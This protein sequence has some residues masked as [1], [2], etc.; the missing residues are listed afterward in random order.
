MNVSVNSTTR[1][2]PPHCYGDPAQWDKNAPECAGG[3][4]ANYQNP[5]TGK[6]VRYPCNF[7]SSCGTR[8]ALAGPRVIPP[9][10][11]VRPPVVTPAPSY[12]PYAAQPPPPQ[13]PPPQPGNLGEY[14]RRVEQERLA[15]LGRQY[16]PPQQY[17]HPGTWSQGYAVPSF[18]SAEEVRH[19]G[20]SWWA[21]FLRMAARGVVKALGMVAAHW[22]DT[23]VMRAAPPPEKKE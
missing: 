19:P 16:Q 23:R 11:L 2:T 22:F 8:A 6:N 14:M 18:L 4:D 3:P 21:P 17:Q 12:Q 1:E 5:H 13:Q 20:E 7:F 10:Q 15:A 9:S